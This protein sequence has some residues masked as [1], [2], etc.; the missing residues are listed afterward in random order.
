M[1]EKVV[2]DTDPGI[3]DAMALAF[4]DCARSLELIGITTTTGNGTI[5][6]TT[7][8]ALHL[9]ERFDIPAPVFRG[10]AAPLVVP[11]GPPPKFVHGDD[12]LGNTEPRVENREVSSLSAAEFLVDCANRYPGEVAIIAVG[13]L[14]NLALALELDPGIAQ[15]IGRIV[16]MGGAFGGNGHSGNITQV[17]EANIHGDPHAADIVLAAGWPVA[18]VPLDVTMQIIMTDERMQRIRAAAGEVGEFMWQVSRFYDAFYRER[19]DIDGFPVH[20]SSA[21]AFAVAPALFDIAV[22]PITVDLEGDDLG[23][24]RRAPD[25]D[26]PEHES[27]VSVDA[28]AV[29]ALYEETLA[30]GPS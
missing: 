6:T 3:D 24:T 28:E 30:Q 12:A 17:A 21:V 10:A 2:F 18:L 20:D 26:R 23:R 14:T 8:N 9:V 1:A 4:I 15:K 27:C 19:H 29:L 7:R 13:R 5:E 16:V 22:A 11:A 25:A